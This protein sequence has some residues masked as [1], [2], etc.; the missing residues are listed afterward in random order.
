MPLNAISDIESNDVTLS[1]AKLDP[2]TLSSTLKAAIGN[3][4]AY[5]LEA[6]VGNTKVSKFN[7]ML[8]I[9]IPYEPEN[10]DNI[11]KITIFY[12]DSEGNLVNMLVILS[13][14]QIQS[15]LKQITS[16]HIL[17]KQMI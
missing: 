10:V 3:S 5:N 17:K 9:S 4:P 1:A 15:T 11:S 7:S 6:Y 13:K 16:V 8:D 14:T 2:N 12:I